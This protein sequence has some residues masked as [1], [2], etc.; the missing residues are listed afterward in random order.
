MDLNLKSL[1][2]I[3]SDARLALALACGLFLVLAG[4]GAIHD[5]PS[6]M[7]PT[8]WIGFLFFGCLWGVEF[9]SAWIATWP[10]K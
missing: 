3:G 5:L 2:E 7:I 4:F 9:L 1:T 8:A 10:D 6:W